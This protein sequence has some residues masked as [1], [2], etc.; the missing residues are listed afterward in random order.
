MTYRELQEKIAEM[1]EQ[2]KNCD[3]TFKDQDDEFFAAKLCFAG[4]KNDVLDLTHPYFTK[5]R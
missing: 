4:K 2:Q 5:R 1:S 3:V